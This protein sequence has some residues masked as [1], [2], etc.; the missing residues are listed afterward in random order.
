MVYAV[1]SVAVELVIL[2][3]SGQTAEALWAAVMAKHD[4]KLSWEEN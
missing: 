1:R 3:S 2:V 4:V